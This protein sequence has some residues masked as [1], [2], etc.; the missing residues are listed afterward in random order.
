MFVKLLLVL[1]SRFS[2]SGE[3]EVM[4]ACRSLQLPGA[5]RCTRLLLLPL[6]LE[7]Q[8]ATQKGCVD[9]VVWELDQGHQLVLEPTPPSYTHC[10]GGTEALSQLSTT[11]DG[12]SGCSLNATVK[13][14]GEKTE[15][16]YSA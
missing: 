4:P 9:M 13:R 2:W 5:D 15:G 11:L 12:F 1:I 14:E 6:L 16:V 7:G 10:F 8:P 3:Q